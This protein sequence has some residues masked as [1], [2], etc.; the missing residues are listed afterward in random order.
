M[1]K[2]AFFLFERRHGRKNIGSS[3]IRGHWLIDKWDE[4]EEMVYGKKY[5]A[6]IYQKV[7]EPSIAKKW[8]EE[9]DTFQILDLCDPDWLDYHPVV[10][11]IQEMDYVTCSSK[12]LETALKDM[13]DKPVKYIPDRV[14]MDKIVMRKQHTGKAK[15][16]GWFGYSHNSYVLEQTLEPLHKEGLELKV[17]SDA[18]YQPRNSKYDD[19][20]EWVKWEDAQQADQELL[21]CDFTVLPAGTN[22][23]FMYKSEN[24]TFHSWALGLPVAKTVEEVRRFVGEKERKK[25]AD[26][27]YKQVLDNLTVEESIKEFK[28]IIKRA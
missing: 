5:D 28:E 21:E 15:K 7:Y 20:V 27:R 12:G 18:M 8:K 3:R 19:M 14:N 10:E 17:I 1:S 26:K 23:R 24:K 11:T 25:E 16:A 2:I 22:P 9:T 13:T 4:A 6:I